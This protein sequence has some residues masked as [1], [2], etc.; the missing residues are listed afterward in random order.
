MLT[1]II[2]IFFFNKKTIKTKSDWIT[3]PFPVVCFRPLKQHKNH[4]TLLS[5]PASRWHQT[6][7]TDKGTDGL[8]NLPPLSSFP[9]SP[10]FSLF[11]T[12]GSKGERERL[13]DYEGFVLQN[14]R[15][16]VGGHYSRLPIFMNHP[17]TFTFYNY[18][19]SL[20]SYLSGWNSN[21]KGPSIFLYIRYSR[22]NPPLTHS[23]LNVVLVLKT[24]FIN[25]N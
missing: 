9:P 12:R 19:C 16:T 1:V 11:T 17:K 4:N 2:L 18:R 10:F 14:W 22:S 5:T 3:L 8:S 13:K 21:P 24:F 7:E 15:T 25:D 23:I 20:P 6:I